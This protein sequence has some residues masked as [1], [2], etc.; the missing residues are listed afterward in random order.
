[1]RARVQ[2]RV[3]KEREKYAKVSETTELIAVEP[4]FK[5]NTSQLL[6]PEAAAYKLSVEIPLPIDVVRGHSSLSAVGL[7]GFSCA[8]ILGW[9]PLA[10]VMLQSQ[11]PVDLLDVDSNIAIIS[12]TPPDRFVCSLSLRHAVPV[13]F[14]LFALC[15]LCRVGAG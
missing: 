6:D 8:L 10:Q 9:V 1:M 2:A 11:I 5:V 4:P 3:E 15:C 13:V 7:L 14:E 12:K